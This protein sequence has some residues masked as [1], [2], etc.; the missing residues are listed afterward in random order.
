MLQAYKEHKVVSSGMRL[1]F[2]YLSY[3]Y[4]KKAQ[5]QQRTLMHITMHTSEVS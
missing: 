3:W 1:R 5:K 4:H 2:Q